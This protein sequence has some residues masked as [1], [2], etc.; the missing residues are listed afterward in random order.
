MIA[1]LPP[2][3]SAAAAAPSMT[4]EAAF[5]MA[6]FAARRVSAPGTVLAGDGP[7]EDKLAAIDALLS[8]IPAAHRP[9]QVATLDA[10]TAAAASAAQPP[11]VRAKALTF[12]GY[13]MNQVPDDAARTRGLAVLLDALKSPVYR[14]YALRGLGP[15]CHDLPKADEG[16]L[17]GALLDLLDGPVAGEERETALV[18]LFS[19]VSTRDDLSKRAPALVAA[20]DAR[21]LAPIEADPAGFESDP[22]GTPGSRA[23]T[24]A[25]FWSSARHRR[26]LGNPAPAA[27]VHALLVKLAALETD[28]TALAWMKTYRDAPE[29]RLTEST[30]KRAPAGPDEP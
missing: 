18:A 19:F 27:R 26:T 30:T 6:R 8:R 9:E 10:L 4:I 23:L 24:A 2:A 22:R 21:L 25:T 5:V 3:V 15:A 7:L 1:A 14:I 12:V 20:L 13:A 29:P 28:P 16:A 17:Q 11:E